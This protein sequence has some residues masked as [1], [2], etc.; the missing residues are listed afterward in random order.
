MLVTIQV[1]WPRNVHKKF[2]LNEGEVK[3]SLLKGGSGWA[4]YY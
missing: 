1:G 4:G 2:Q 3:F